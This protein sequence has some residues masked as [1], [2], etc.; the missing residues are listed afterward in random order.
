MNLTTSGGPPLPTA[1]EARWAGRRGWSLR[2][3]RC[4]LFGATWQD[5]DR[6][7][8]NLALCDEHTAELAA[9][10]A[11]HAA[12]MAEL[13]KVVYPNL[14]PPRMPSQAEDRRRR[15]AFERGESPTPVRVFT[16]EGR[17]AHV[18]VGGAGLLDGA[19]ACGLTT[20]PFQGWRGRSD[21]AERAEAARRPLCRRCQSLVQP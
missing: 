2:C 20:N 14:V 18:L 17:V 13:T 10:R 8:R 1:D 3:G 6:P 7:G 21:D 11:R 12:A 19:T 15:A 16:W 4:G 9:E 5:G